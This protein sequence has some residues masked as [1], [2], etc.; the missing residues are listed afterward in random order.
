[1][2]ENPN[3]EEFLQ[4]GDGF[5]AGFS[6]WGTVTVAS[7]VWNSNQ[8]NCIG[9]SSVFCLLIGNDGYWAARHPVLH[10]GRYLYPQYPN[11]ILI[12][13]PDDTTLQET[14]LN[15]YNTS[16][17]DYDAR[18]LALNYLRQFRDGRTLDPGSRVAR[19]ISDTLESVL[20]VE[21]FGGS[22]ENAE[23]AVFATID[24]YCA[25]TGPECDII[26][27]IEYILYRI[28]QVLILCISVDPDDCEVVPHP[29]PVPGTV[30]PGD[31]SDPVVEIAKTGTDELLISAVPAMPVATFNAEVE[32][33]SGSEYQIEYDWHAYLY[34]RETGK[35]RQI[36][37]FD[38][39]VEVEDEDGNMVT[40]TVQMT[41]R[42]YVDKHHDFL[43][44]IPR[45]GTVSGLA[46]TDV[47][48]NSWTIPWGNILQG[49]NLTVEV[50][51]TVSS[52]GNEIAKVSDQEVFPITGTNPSLEK[53]KEIIGESNEKM[54]VAWK[55]SSHR[56]FEGLQYGGTG[57][58]VYGPP[59]G[60]G[61]MQIDNI[62][63]VTKTVGHFWNWRTNLSTGSTYLDDLYDDAL[64]YFE[65][66][67][68]PNFSGDSATGWSWDPTKA[69]EDDTVK[70]RIWDDAFSRYNTG[71][72]MYSPN[73]NDGKKH[74]EYE[75]EHEKILD[76]KT[77]TKYD[78]F[79][80]PIGCK[81][82]EE[83][84]KIM[85]E[86]PWNDI[87]SGDRL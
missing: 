39:T 5:S 41:K 17:F 6:L 30:D 56:Q 9:F 45:V 24:S 81:Y 15:I 25:T 69:D 49:G 36:Y 8:L 58:P 50:T 7:Q 82:A 42:F 59:D 22:L 43:E 1:M 46:G 53:M 80:N 54:A 78:P 23:R 57:N 62:P 52:G 35:K 60:W 76:K 32:G 33:L 18:L 71:N 77:K 16:Q 10:R 86:K 67:H 65:E 68:V 28:R 12:V 48:N 26:K 55:E 83:I 63:G 4:S 20:N 61:L 66:H 72:P 47:F 21:V 87:P 84:R 27:V 2:D 44:R 14:N 79:M 74:C 51:A 3:E 13:I 38:K 85:K 34:N 19:V 37:Q 31:E 70:E 75:V 11:K 73:G 29:L 40:R 64:M